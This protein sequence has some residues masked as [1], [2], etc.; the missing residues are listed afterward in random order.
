[1]RRRFDFDGE[2]QR[3]GGS[4]PL[5]IGSERTLE[6]DGQYRKCFSNRYGSSQ[7]GSRRGKPLVVSLEGYGTAKRGWSTV[8]QE[9]FFHIRRRG[10]IMQ[11]SIG[12][13]EKEKA[14]GSS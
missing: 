9:G 13:L 3:K 1:M 5:S 4:I 14:V 8:G 11:Q 2:T 6:R 12:D 10:G 7:W